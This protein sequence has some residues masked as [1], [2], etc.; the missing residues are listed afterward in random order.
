[1]LMRPVAGLW[2]RVKSDVTVNIKI[3][4]DKRVKV[5]RIREFSLVEKQLSF[6]KKAEHH[7]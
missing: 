7:L 1:M 5:L 3:K 4:R 2:A 6:K